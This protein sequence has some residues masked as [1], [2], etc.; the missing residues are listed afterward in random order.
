MLSGRSGRQVWRTA[1]VCLALAANLIA[2]GVPVLHASAHAAHDGAQHAEAHAPE[3]HESD[4][5]EPE[6]HAHEEPAPVAA[7]PVDDA[8]PG[9]DQGHG[10]VHPASLHD[11]CI[12]GKRAVFSFE[13]F[14]ALPSFDPV[15]PTR[16]G[17]APSRSIQRLSTRAPPPGTPARAPPLV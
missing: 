11:E 13:W 2:A 10:D 7:E 15:I 17:G 14:V 9:A 8:D 1:T 4:T 12:S 16:S 5:H 6:A 3:A